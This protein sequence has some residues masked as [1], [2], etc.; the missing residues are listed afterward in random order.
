[1]PKRGVTIAEKISLFEKIKNQPPN[2]SHRQLAEI[3]GVSKSAVTR[4]VQQQG[5]LRVE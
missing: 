1:M 4:V 3:T 2:T 5:K